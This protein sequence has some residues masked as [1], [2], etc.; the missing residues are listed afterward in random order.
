[1]T[2]KNQTGSGSVDIPCDRCD[3]TITMPAGQDRIE[4]PHCGDM[5]RISRSSA[6]ANHAEEKILL[7]TRPA[8][9]RGH[10]LSATLGGIG[11]LGGLLIALLSWASS[12]WPDW[13]V[14][15]GLIAAVIAGGW[16]SWVFIF[17]HRW[18]RLRITNRRTIDE[19]GIVMK[20]TSEVLHNHVRNIRITQTIWQRIMRIGDI[21]ID[22]AAGKDG[23]PDI[24]I[25]DIP[26]PE[27]LKRLIDSHR[28]LGD[29]DE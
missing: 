27:G 23:R 6:A 19:R 20:R 1:M 4:C 28:G 3:R 15:P 21:E 9:V 24:T 11:L 5:N 14:W 7:L 13:L 12:E 29:S 25:A 16:L 2:D 18:D 26:N 17:G 8:L 10:P 22:G